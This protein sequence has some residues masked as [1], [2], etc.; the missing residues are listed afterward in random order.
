MTTVAATNRS[1]DAVGVLADL[2]KASWY[3][4]LTYVG[5][6]LVWI[7]LPSLALGW[8]PLVVTS[9]SMGP[10]INR[11]DVVVVE[12]GVAPIAGNVVAFAGS[13]GSPVLH[14][15]ERVNPDGTFTTRGDANNESDST[16]VTAVGGVGRLLIPGLGLVKLLLPEAGAIL[17]FLTLG[18]LLVG[19][20][21]R[22]AALIASGIVVGA[23]LFSVSTIFVATAASASSGFQTVMIGPPTNVTA[24]CS[25]VGAGGSVPISI[26]WNASA[27]GGIS[28]Y[29]VFWD[30][31]PPGGGFVLLGST[32]ATV[33]NHTIPGGQLGLGQAHTYQV[34]AT[35]GPWFSVTAQDQ[36]TVTQ[37]LFVYTCS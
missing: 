9:G 33:F 15:V 28:G 8:I 13:D 24:T 3:F 11:G 14:R 22:W 30:A 5:A 6:T 31:A 27:T 16:P 26:S 1:T 18:A 23:I 25:P 2:V 37:V 19:L 35:L 12:P 34:R 32:G 20:R 17:A 29:E 7:L 36:V 4:L 21:R 10:L